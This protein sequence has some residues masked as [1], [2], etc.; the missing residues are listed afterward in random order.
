M[1]VCDWQRYIFHNLITKLTLAI[2]TTFLQCKVGLILGILKNTGTGY[3]MENEVVKCYYVLLLT[4]IA[5]LML[6]Y[7]EW[8]DF[9]L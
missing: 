4:V 8:R 5:K 3:I 7:E 2:G 1:L 9:F 6:N